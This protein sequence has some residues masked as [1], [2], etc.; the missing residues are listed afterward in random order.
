MVESGV[1]RFVEIGPGSV[2]CGLSRRNV[3]GTPAISV[4]TARGVRELF[5]DPVAAESGP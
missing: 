5:P 2:L 1:E 4:G 3:R